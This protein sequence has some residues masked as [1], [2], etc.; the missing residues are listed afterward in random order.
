MEHGLDFSLCDNMSKDPNLVLIKSL[1][2]RS[3]RKRET[4]Y[5]KVFEFFGSPEECSSGSN[6]H[7]GNFAQC[8]DTGNELYDPCHDIVGV[9][10][11]MWRNPVREPFF[12]SQ[13]L[14]LSSISALHSLLV[15][16]WLQTRRP[17]ALLSSTGCTKASLPC[18]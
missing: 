7:G 16:G 3:T 17:V 4:Q 1:K 2:F 10:Q 8:N 13:V 11:K 12:R 6:A 14:I 9:G 5:L 15:A 18:R